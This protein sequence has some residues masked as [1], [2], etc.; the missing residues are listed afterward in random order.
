MCRPLYGGIA[1]THF[2]GF[3]DSLWLRLCPRTTESS[4]EDVDV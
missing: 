1:L 3:G 2:G 4:L